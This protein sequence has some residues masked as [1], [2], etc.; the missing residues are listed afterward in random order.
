M[1][2]VL[3]PAESV[4]EVVELLGV[5]ELLARAGLGRDEVESSE[6]VVLGEREIDVEERVAIAKLALLL[7]A[8][9]KAHRNLR[10]QRLRLVAEPRAQASGDRRKEH[11]V[12]RGAS[13]ARMTDPL[14]AFERGPRSRLETRKALAYQGFLSRGDRI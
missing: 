9:M 14:Q 10:S 5:A 13:R 1:A 4:E 6:R 8:M 2:D 12:H 7:G 3:E 11:V